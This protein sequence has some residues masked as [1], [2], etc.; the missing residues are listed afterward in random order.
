MHVW[1]SY[2]ALAASARFI[3]GE[4]KFPVYLLEVGC[5]LEWKS[6]NVQQYAKGWRGLGPSDRGHVC[7]FQHIGALLL[8][9]CTVI[10]RS[11]CIA[12]PRKEVLSMQM[13]SLEA[14]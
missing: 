7:H 14:L 4:R 10:I 1:L 9:R 13:T 5:K 11:L 6:L 3:Q 12:R 8:R 2:P